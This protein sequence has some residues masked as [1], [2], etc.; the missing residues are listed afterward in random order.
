MWYQFNFIPDYFYKFLFF[1]LTDVDNRIS[2]YLKHIDLF[3]HRAYTLGRN[4]LVPQGESLKSDKRS[5]AKRRKEL[6][7][8]LQKF[9]SLREAG[10]LKEAMEQYTKTVEFA[11][12]SINQSL[13]ILEKSIS[14]I[15]SLTPHQQ[16]RIDEITKETSENLEGRDV[17]RD[18]LKDTIFNQK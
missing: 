9:H 13:A 14:R 2:A 4:L 6:D 16:A 10:K 1:L 17:L 18:L 15:K 12:E 3:I 11:R 5:F 7:L 8:H